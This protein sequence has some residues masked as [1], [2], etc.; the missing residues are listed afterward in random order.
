[1]DEPDAAVLGETTSS[2]PGAGSEKSAGCRVLDADRLADALED[3]LA[4]RVIAIAQRRRTRRRDAAR[5]ACR[6][7]ARR[8]RG[9]ALLERPPD[10]LPGAVFGVVTPA[11]S[12]GRG[13][14][15]GAS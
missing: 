3:R 2:R 4:G 1:M 9:R 11:P 12:S 13:H 5:T 10:D 7:A 14:G 6:A 15:A 8:G